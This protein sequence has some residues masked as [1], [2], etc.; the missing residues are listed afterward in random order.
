MRPNVLKAV[1]A[2]RSFLRRHGRTLG[3]SLVLLLILMLSLLPAVVDNTIIGYLPVLMVVFCTLFSLGY[4]HLLKKGITF[5][6]VLELCDCVRGETVNVGVTV[7]NRSLLL[8][9]RVDVSLFI[10]DLTGAVDVCTRRRLPLLPGESKTLSM[11]A[12][13][14]H[15]GCYKVG[16]QSLTVYD[17][18]GLFKCEVAAEGVKEVR[19]EPRLVPLDQLALRHRRI[20]D[21]A[22]CEQSVIADGLDYVGMRNYVLGDSM[23][24]IHWKASARY[25]ELMTRLYERQ[26]DSNVCIVLDSDTRW[27]QGERMMCLYDAVVETV[28]SIASHASDCGIECTVVLAD[29]RGSL[30]EFLPRRPWSYV[31]LLEAVPRLYAAREGSSAALAIRQVTRGFYN[32]NNLIVCSS[33]P[34]EE[35]VSEMISARAVGKHAEL[36]FAQ[37]GD[38]ERAEEDY[39]RRMLSRL[40]TAQVPYRVYSNAQDLEECWQ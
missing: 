1:R 39:V 19:V 29:S 32:S 11:T 3:K 7:N 34:N 26:V 2:T 30:H 15:I 18:F 38:L 23:K 40:S 4:L 36:L 31:D 9:T 33:N 13:F 28:L 21:N 5:E 17:L 20:T 6:E 12:R 14:D 22:N 10:S 27:S 37:P 25:E 16:V 8:C 35:L 24:V